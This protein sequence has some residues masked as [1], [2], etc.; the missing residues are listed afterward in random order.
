MLPGKE[1]KHCCLIGHVTCVIVLNIYF[2]I[3][4][5]FHRNHVL[6]YDYFPTSNKFGIGE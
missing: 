1:Q 5:Y 6:V 2:K 3:S 4:F